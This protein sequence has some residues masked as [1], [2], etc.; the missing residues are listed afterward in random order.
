MPAEL[1]AGATTFDVASLDRPRVPDIWSM[2]LAVAALLIAF[3]WLAFHR[4]WAP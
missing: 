3:E 4:R 1:R 2:L